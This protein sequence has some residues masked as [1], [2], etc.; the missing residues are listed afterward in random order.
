MVYRVFRAAVYSLMHNFR[1]DWNGRLQPCLDVWT[2]GRL[3][4]TVVWTSGRGRIAVIERRDGSSRGNPSA[5]RQGSVLR[6]ES[7]TL[8]D[9]QADA[10]TDALREAAEHDAAGID[11][12]TLATKADLRAEASPLR[13]ASTAPCRCRPTVRVGLLGLLL[14]ALGWLG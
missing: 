13:H 4:V 11:V 6:R 8:S 2:S 14:G 1:S 12:E 10:L 9:K 3:D 7:S 5:M